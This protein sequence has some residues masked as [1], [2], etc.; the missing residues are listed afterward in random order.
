[1]KPGLIA[2]ATILLILGFFFLAARAFFSLAIPNLGFANIDV[3]CILIPIICI[4]F[5]IVLFILGIKA[6]DLHITQGVATKKDDTKDE[7]MRL[8]D[9]RF[10]KGE[11][12]KDQY[13]EM[14]EEIK[15]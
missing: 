14:R 15:K 11:I 5:G 4:I 7:A 9:A 8:L 1:M 10:A 2:L 12:T 6:S 3:V 13:N